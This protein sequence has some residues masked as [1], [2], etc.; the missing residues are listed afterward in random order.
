MVEGSEVLDAAAPLPHS[1]RLKLAILYAATG[2]VAGLAL[3]LGIVIVMA[4]VSDRLRRR[5]DVAHALGAP[6]NLS[7]G[8]VPRRPRASG[9]SGP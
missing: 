7:V 2:L 9:R 1:G 3:G 8:S 5:D 4:L 6:V